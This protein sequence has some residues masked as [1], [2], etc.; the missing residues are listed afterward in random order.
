MS[1]FRSVPYPSRLVLTLLS[2]IASW[3]SVSSMPIN[4][5]VFRNIS[6]F[7][8]KGVGEG[9]GIA[10]G[11]GDGKGDGEGVCVAAFSGRFAAATPA[12]PRAGRS[13]T[14]ARRSMPLETFVRLVGG[15]FF[16]IASLKET[17]HVKEPTVTQYRISHRSA[18]I[19]ADQKTPGDKHLKNSCQS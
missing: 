15:V 16:F 5:S 8:R 2:A 14:N 10:V 4:C 6:L 12:A 7:T 11:D 18:Q 1:I 3:A 19:N 9:D 13:A 17:F